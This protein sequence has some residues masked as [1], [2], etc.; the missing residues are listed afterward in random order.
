MIGICPN[1]GERY[2]YNSYDTDYVHN[3]RS[4]NEYKDFDDVLVIGDYVDETTGSIIT[5]TNTNLQGMENKIQGTNAAID[6]KKVH[7]LTRKGNIKSL[8]RQRRHDEYIKL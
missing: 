5:K 3:C 1:C 4:D 2:S 6:G 8:Y 7:D